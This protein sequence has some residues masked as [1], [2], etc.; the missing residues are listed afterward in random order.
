MNKDH[1]SQ[2]CTNMVAKIIKI[3]KMFST[4]FFKSFLKFSLIKEIS[5]FRY[6]SADGFY[7]NFYIHHGLTKQKTPNN[8]FDNLNYCGIIFIR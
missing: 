2:L 7:P 1:F 3:R 6:S 4:S 5:Q 8:V